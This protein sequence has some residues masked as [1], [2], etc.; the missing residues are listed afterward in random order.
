MGQILLVNRQIYKE[1]SFVFY[2]KNIFAIGTGPYGS[3]RMPNLQGLECFLRS[4]PWKH[5]C[6]VVKLSVTIFL[7]L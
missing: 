6:F 5:T 7:E 1:A 2:S 4:V 3:T